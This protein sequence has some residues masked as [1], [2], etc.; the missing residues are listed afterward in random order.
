MASLSGYIAVACGV[1]AIAILAHYLW[2]KPPLDLRNKLW[3]F[4]GL[5][6][7][8]AIA[9]GTGT[10]K[11][12]HDATERRFCGSCHVMDAHVADASDPHSTSLAARHGRNP[13]FGGENCYVCHADY[14]MFG[15]ALTKLN[16][17]KHVY[18]Y[19]L[20]GYRQMSLDEAVSK[21]HLYKP[22]D[23]NN[24]M[25]CH[26]GTLQLWQ[27]VPEHASMLSDLQQNRVS[28]ASGGCHGYAHPF[29]KQDATAALDHTP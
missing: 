7:L 27:Q 19:Y 8:P 1:L 10:A 29:S 17:M 6:I 9:S 11:G 12:L 28:C 20:G 25:Q 13:Y 23:N 4:L 24:C 2:A 5:G 22:Y 3:L 16:G 14:G 18:E 15:Y 21:I 26:S